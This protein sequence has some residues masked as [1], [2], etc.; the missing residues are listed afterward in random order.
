[1]WT[2]A[3]HLTVDVHNNSQG[4]IL[5]ICSGKQQNDKTKSDIRPGIK[6]N[7][8]N[9]TKQLIKQKLIHFTRGKNEMI[10]MK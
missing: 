6:F 1:M 2:D 7:T 5:N 8:S 3:G 10:K 4:K 9:P